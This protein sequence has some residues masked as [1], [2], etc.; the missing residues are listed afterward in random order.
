MT[1]NIR[2]LM[3]LAAAVLSLLA[4]SCIE[5]GFTTSPSD[6]PAFS[7][8]TLRIGDVYTDELTTTRRMTVYNRHDKGLMLQRVEL[9][10]ENAGLFRINVDGLSGE[11]FS[12]IEIRAKDS[13]F[14][15]VEA[16]LPENGADEPK[17]VEASIDF[18]VNGLTS[19]VVVSAV[20]QDI[21]R[22]RGVVIDRDTRFT[23]GKPYQVFDS[24][25]VAPGATLTIEAGARVFFHDKAWMGVFG[26]LLCNGTPE[27][28]VRLTGDRTGDVLPG[29][30][31]DLMSRQWDCIDFY[32]SSQGN[33][34][35]HTE[36]SNSS[37]G[38]AVYG[39]GS[40]L[41]Q[42]KLTL[43]N[44]KLRN[45]GECVLLA[46]N[47]SVEAY[48]C[49]F[50]EAGYG[51]VY[52]VGGDHRFDH[53]TVSNHYLFKAIESAAWI[54]VDPSK[55]EMYADAAP[56]KALITNTIT[57]G[58]GAEAEPADLSGQ[59]IYFSRCLF[60]SDGKDDDNF[61]DCLWDA[62]PLFYTVREDYVFDYRLKPESPAIGAASDELSA[63]PL[64]DV[65]FYGLARERDLGAYVYSAPADE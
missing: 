63:N 57:W 30:S 47:A 56:T 49:E 62:D 7:T 29:V 17:L 27:A 55:T 9:S 44:C 5:D 51:L 65:D 50:A 41:D 12:D 58:L 6:Q 24:L 18:T 14:V 48:G 15:F 19:S 35:E 1:K 13:I 28:P 59:E 36:I 32:P 2:I 26:T 38:V 21:N 52:L 40:D 61:T 23:A 20:G 39:D 45:S 25:V 37:L 34:L 4:A 46:F 31:F 16:R 3:A 53:C 64:S 33:R 43:V 22:L 60:K 42:K 8:D 10:G 11:S 54:F